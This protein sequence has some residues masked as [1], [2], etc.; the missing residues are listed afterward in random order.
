[1]LQE[2]EIIRLA[3]LLSQVKPSDTANPIGLASPQS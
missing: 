2:L 3:Y 1:M